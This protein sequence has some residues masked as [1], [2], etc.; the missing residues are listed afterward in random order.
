MKIHKLTYLTKILNLTT[1]EN[2]LY[3]FTSPTCRDIL[4]YVILRAGNKNRIKWRMKRGK[5]TKTSRRLQ[6]NPRLET[7]GVMHQLRK[8]SAE[9]PW[10]WWSLTHR[11]EELGSVAYHT[12]YADSKSC[13]CINHRFSEL[14]MLHLYLCDG[15]KCNLLSFY[16]ILSCRQNLHIYWD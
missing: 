7:T 1:T 14:G 12:P 13:M 6:I 11:D 4:D 9:F 10:N 3:I 2:L 8:I 5:K 16:F 15:R